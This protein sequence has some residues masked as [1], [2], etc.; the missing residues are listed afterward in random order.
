MAVYSSPDFDDATTNPDECVDVDRGTKADA[1]AMRDVRTTTAAEIFIF[2]CVV[3]DLDADWCN[4]L[5]Y[6]TS[7]TAELSL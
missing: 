3:V 1:D 7:K 6:E 4:E 2:V 5:N